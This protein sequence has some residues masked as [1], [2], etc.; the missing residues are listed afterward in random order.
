MTAD[1][2]PLWL[3]WLIAALLLTSGVFT[4]AAAW[5]LVRLSSF[6]QRMHP[7][8]LVYVWSSWCVTLASILFFSARHRG[9]QLHVWLIIILLS[10]TVPITTVLLS[11]AALFRHRV[12][13][14]PDVPPPLPPQ[15]PPGRDG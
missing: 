13:G 14:R 7:P 2:L 9:P 6:Y 1:A 10:I 15:A 3:Q 11:R 12:A 4:L 8:A 5:G